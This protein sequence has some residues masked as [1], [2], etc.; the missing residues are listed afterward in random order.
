MLLAN[1]RLVGRPDLVDV[2]LVDGRVARIAPAP[3]SPAGVCAAPDGEHVDLDG[4]HLLPGFWD[5]HVHLLQQ[6][7]AARRLDVASARS[8]REAADLVAARVRRDPPRPGEVVV[9][10]GFRAVGWPDQPTAALL[11]AAG[12]GAPVALTSGDLHSGWFSTAALARLGLTADASGLVREDDFFPVAG[13]LDGGTPAERDA[14]VRAAAAQAATRGVVGVVDMEAADPRE[15]T[16]RLGGGPGEGPDVTRFPIRVEAAVWP[17]DVEAVLAAGLRPGDALAGAR[18]AVGHALVRLGPLKVISDGSLNTRTAYCHDAYPGGGRG[19]LNVGPGE[20]A[21]LL[22]RAHGAGL[23]CAVHAIGDAAAA[24]ALDAFAATGAAGSLEHAQL[25]ATTDLTRLAALGLVASV[26]PAHLLDDRDVAEELWPGRTAR[27]YRF[28]DLLVAGVRLALGS[29]APVAAL[30]PLLA[31]AAAVRRTGDA[32]PP[33]HPEQRI[34]AVAA[35]LASTGGCGVR[36]SV[37]QVADLV[38][39][40]GDPVAW[41]SE[42]TA[43]GRPRALGVA[44]TLL[45]GEWTHRSL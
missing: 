42:S 39:L 11:D 25:L 8:A 27:A 29:D 4:R 15:W 16:R 3:A 33:W 12:G 35:L 5:A 9:G 30:D 41:A 40:D 14:W 44:G 17:Q 7:L 23:R 21:P 45:A 22:A 20:L 19:T 2:L 36:P 10:F 24:L 31:V 38:V 37:G 6:A 32:R 43:G 26:Q 1:A 13:A 18:D 34:G 28:A